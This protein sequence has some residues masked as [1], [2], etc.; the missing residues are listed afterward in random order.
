MIRLVQEKDYPKLVKLCCEDPIYGN[1]ILSNWEACREDWNAYSFWIGEDQEKKP[2][3]A[4]CRVW[5]SYIIAGLK[6]PSDFLLNE[7]AQLFSLQPPEDI[8]A[9]SKTTEPLNRYL[10]MQ[11]YSSVSMLRQVKLDIED[12]PLFAQIRPCQSL[13]DFYNIAAEGFDYFR[14]TTIMD[15]WV[16]SLFQKRRQG[17]VSVYELVQEGKPVCI[18]LLTCA[19][20]SPYATINT[21]TTREAWQGKGL[22]SAMVKFLCKKSEL[23]GRTVCLDCGEPSLSSFYK[24]FGFETIHRWTILE[25]Q[26]WK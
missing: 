4:L 19:T 18:A 5:S 7:L 8:M 9:I 3:Y 21:L 25:T 11:T 14:Q 6:D 16:C 22:A 1:I 10:K 15:R 12:D 26:F 17:S 24:K 23:M 13:V 20:D 2:C